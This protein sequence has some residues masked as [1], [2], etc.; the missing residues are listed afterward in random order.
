MRDSPLTVERLRVSDPAAF[1]A[2]AGPLTPEWEA[3]ADRC[4]AEPWLRPGWLRAWWHAFGTGRLQLLTARRT[5]DA[6]LVALVALRR[7][8]GAVSSPTNWHSPRYGVLAEHPAARRAVLGALLATR[9]RAIDLRCLESADADCLVRQSRAAGYRVLRRTVQRSPF[10]RIS[11]PWPAYERTTAAKV[12][13]EIARRRRRLEQQGRLELTVADG[14]RDL[15]DLLGEGLRVEAAGWKGRQRTA[16]ASRP[17]TRQFY[18]ELAAWAADRGWLRLAFLRLDGRTLAFDLA[19]EH[20]GH[21]YLLKTGYD[22][23]FHAQAPGKIIRQEMLAR[24]FQNRLTSYEFLGTDDAWKREWTW[25]SHDRVRVQAFGT[26]PLA[27]LL[28]VTHAYGRPLAVS[29]AA[30]AG[31]PRRAA[32]R[33]TKAAPSSDSTHRGRP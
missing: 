30:R 13:R 25:T 10:V 1:L 23:A 8:R 19:L 9:P 15:D 24:A 17:D 5:S 28:W 21:H 6:E 27:Q 26:S 22:P 20:A 12:R 29:L 2:D 33:A 31:L 11:G 7:R 14:Q 32:D 3:L 16:I 18:G 4:D